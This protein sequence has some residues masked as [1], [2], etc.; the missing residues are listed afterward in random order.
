MRAGV[1]KGRKGHRRAIGRVRDVVSHNVVP[2]LVDQEHDRLPRRRLE[3]H[4]MPR[5]ASRR[6]LQRRDGPELEAGRIEGED[7]DEVGAEVRQQQEPTGRVRQ[8]LVRV[9]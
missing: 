5:S 2:E 3:K 7:A 6:G 4:G 9:R 8:R 1:E